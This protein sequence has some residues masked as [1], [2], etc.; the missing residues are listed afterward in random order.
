M[1]PNQALIMPN[2]AA[3]DSKVELLPH[4]GK[5]GSLL[6]PL[7]QEQ[8]RLISVPFLP[9]CRQGGDLEF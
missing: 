7:L 8:N 1:R 6:Q 4:S 9:I 5:K 2:C 3:L